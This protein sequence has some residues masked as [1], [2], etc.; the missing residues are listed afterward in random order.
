MLSLYRSQQFLWPELTSNQPPAQAGRAREAIETAAQ[1]VLDTRAQFPDSSLADLY[2]PLSMPPALVK[3]H[4]KLDAAVDA[5][6]A[7]GGAATGG[8]RPCPERLRR[9]YG[10]RAGVPGPGLA[11]ILSICRSG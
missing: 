3:A 1:T 7:L 6:Y 5:A 11:A 9:P 10:Q 4:Q 8:W 2:D